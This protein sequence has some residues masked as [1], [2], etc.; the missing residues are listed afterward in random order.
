MS[1]D[2]DRIFD[3]LLS[4]AIKYTPHGGAVTVR[5]DC[6]AEYA[7]IRVIDTGMGIPDESQPRLF[8]EFYRAPNAREQVKEGTGL[9]LAIAKSLVSRF[10]GRISVKSKLG[11]GTECIV[12]LP[13]KKTTTLFPGQRHP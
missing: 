6:V 3:N 5:L 7:H 13:I 2:I 10:G 11:E 9:G 8:E 1:E 12:M 4:N